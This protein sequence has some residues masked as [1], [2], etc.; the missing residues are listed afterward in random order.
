MRLF[1]AICFPEDVKD[2]LAGIVKDLSDQAAGNFTRR[3]NFHLTLAFL[4]ET[5]R[6]RAIQAAMKQV[7]GSGAFSMELANLGRF[8]RTGG[9]IYWMGI[10]PCPPL[11]AL[12][13]R[14]AKSLQGAG[15]SL[16]ERSFSPHLTLGREV[17][18]GANFDRDTFSGAMPRLKVPVEKICLME[19]RREAGVLVYREV[20][21][22][23]L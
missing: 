5:P 19:S 23:K 21:S 22:I 12:Q 3:E 20:S 11:A 7:E 4:G 9:D 16:E 10:S 2:Q 14:L 6:L 15:F 8:R 13:K 17:K 18:P 1:V